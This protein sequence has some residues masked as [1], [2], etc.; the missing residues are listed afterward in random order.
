MNY[1]KM[2]KSLANSEFPSVPHYLSHME[3]F[4]KLSSKQTDAERYRQKQLLTQISR[5]QQTHH[6]R[7]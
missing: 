5:T 4:T 7:S 2:K 3:A 6:Q 1:L